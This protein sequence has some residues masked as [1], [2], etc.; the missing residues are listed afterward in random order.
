MIIPE[1]SRKLIEAAIRIMQGPHAA[2]FAEAT[3]HS[4]YGVAWADGA[5]QTSGKAERDLASLIPQELLQ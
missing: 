1:E 3:I 2:E 5:I 4:V